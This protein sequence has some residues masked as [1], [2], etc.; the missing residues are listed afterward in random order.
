MGLGSFLID[1]HMDAPE[2]EAL[3]LLR[4]VAPE[5]GTLPDLIDVP[6]YPTNGLYPS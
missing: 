2:D 4:A 5:L 1:N 3:Q 6:L